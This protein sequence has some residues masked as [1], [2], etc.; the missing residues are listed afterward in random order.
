[1]PDQVATALARLN[2]AVEALAA[3]AGT[4]ESSEAWPDAIASLVSPCA[5][6][7]TAAAVAGA[8]RRLSSAND[9]NDDTIREAGAIPHL[10][11]LLA[12]GVDRERAGEVAGR[13]VPPGAHHRAE[14]GA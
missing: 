2:K 10:V 3:L 11:A 6:P 1:M 8:L 7:A 14:V 4:H 9:A 12:G 5:A 13:I